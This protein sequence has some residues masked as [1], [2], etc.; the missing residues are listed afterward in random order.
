MVRKASIS[1]AMLLNI[2]TFT[3]KRGSAQRIFTSS[4]DFTLGLGSSPLSTIWMYCLT[5]GQ[6]SIPLS[7]T[8][9]FSIHRCLQNLSMGVLQPD[10]DDELYLS[11]THLSHTQLYR[12]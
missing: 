1:L 3:G 11:H 7:D 8:L 2:P 10:D 6:C 4:N 5:W 9:T 12:V